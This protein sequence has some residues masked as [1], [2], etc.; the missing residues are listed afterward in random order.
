[1]SYAVFV[2][3]LSSDSNKLIP[4]NSTVRIE[5][6]LLSNL[7]G[8]KGHQYIIDSEVFYIIAL[9]VTCFSYQTSQ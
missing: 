6:R 8:S 4:V 7:C 9:E 1:M 5:V 3:C 2:G